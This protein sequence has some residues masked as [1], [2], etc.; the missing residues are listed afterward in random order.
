MR[1][2]EHVGIADAI[3]NGDPDKARAVVE[4]HMAAFTTRYLSDEAAAS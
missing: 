4:S 1:Y 3:D 2:A